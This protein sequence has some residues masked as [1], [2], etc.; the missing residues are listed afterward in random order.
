MPEACKNYTPWPSARAA[1]SH[2]LDP[3]ASGSRSLSHSCPS[4][5]VD[6]TRAQLGEPAIGLARVGL[7]VQTSGARLESRHRWCHPS[8]ATTFNVLNAGPPLMR[9]IPDGDTLHLTGNTARVSSGPAHRDGAR[10]RRPL[11]ACGLDDIPRCRSNSDD[12]GL[13]RQPRNRRSSIVLR[14]INRRGARRPR[15][16]CALPLPCASA[17]PGH[18]SNSRSSIRR[19]HR[20]TWSNP[21]LL[22]TPLGR[23]STDDL[24]DM[25][26]VLGEVNA[27]G[28]DAVAVSWQG[29]AFD[30]GSNH[31]RMM[32]LLEA[33]RRAGLRACV[34]LETTVANPEHEQNGIAPN[35]DTVLQWLQD[36]VDAYADHPAYL[37]V[38]ERPVVFAYAAQRLTEPRW[39]DV[40]G[41]LRAGG[42]EVL[43][44]GEG[45]NTT[46]LGAFQGL[47]YYASNQFAGEA[48][49]DFNRR[50]SLGARTYHLLPGDDGGRRSGWPRSARATT[51]LDSPTAACP[52][53]PIATTAAITTR[54]GKPRSRWAPTG[55]PSPA[56]TNGGRTPP[57]SPASAMATSTSGRHWPGPRASGALTGSSRD[58]PRYRA[59][60]IVHS[61]RPLM[62]NRAVA[63]DSL[64]VP[65]VT[66][67]STCG[68]QRP[69]PDLL[70]HRPERRIVDPRS[71]RHVN[72]L[73]GIVLVLRAVEQH[74]ILLQVPRS[75]A[76]MAPRKHRPGCRR[77]ATHAP[78]EPAV[79]LRDSRSTPAERCRRGW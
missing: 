27:A 76:P 29:L 48:I 15:T 33:A 32:V 69:P 44:I 25:V 14:S 38:D 10:R 65:S 63:P 74:H 17:R 79:C 57:S 2:K 53:S 39:R 43:L 35:P 20:D 19:C 54:S 52:A 1:A 45:S 34:L 31:R 28:L 16:G 46:R 64:S 26:R 49:R 40:L 11:G 59:N 67:P 4:H 47:F 13:Q 37:R 23:Y 9:V 55:S 56:G 70:R 51:T 73:F 22:D 6:W 3:W 68:Y 8:R 12:R 5:R 41:R 62:N 30:G 7:H 36:V 78:S 24:D 71:K 58:D 66:R 77:R 72:A 61:D 42:R 21:Q 75:S 60:G 50:E 18:V